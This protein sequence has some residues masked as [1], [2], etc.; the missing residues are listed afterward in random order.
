MARQIGKV[1][2]IDVAKHKLDW[3]IRQV[4]RGSTGN[5][6]SDC[7]ALAKELLRHGVGEVVLEASGGYEATATQ[8]LRAAGVAVRIVDPKRVR[9]FAQAAGRQAK[10]DPMDAQTIAWFGEIFDA[11][12]TVPP[13]P[14]REK[15]AALVSE[16]QDFVLMK[17][18]LIQRGEHSRSSLGE[19]QRKLMLKQL[20]RVIEK[21]DAAIAAKI[22]DTPHL[23]QQYRLLDSVPGLGLQ[24]IA[25]LLAWLPELGRIDGNKIAA[26]VGVAPYDDDSGDRKGLRRIKGGRADLRNIFY[27][28]VMGAATQHNETLN[29]FYLGL[30]ARGKLRK[31]ALV[32]CMRKLLTIINL[33]VARQQPWCPQQQP[34]EVAA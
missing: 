17:T 25:A 21:F 32:A 5:T 2:G 24:A 1:A 11:E 14:D 31:V 33:M 27:M 4:A 7:A 18:Q 9:R 30:L 23:D 8:A 34:C 10:N 16:R 13:D 3:C 19:Q 28:A 22:A 12:V 26:L 15:L 20:V 29:R 6:Q